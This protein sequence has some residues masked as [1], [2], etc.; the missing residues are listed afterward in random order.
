MQ[1]RVSSS[2][3]LQSAAVCFFSLL[4]V[5]RCNRT[6]V[7]CTAAAEHENHHIL[8]PSASVRVASVAPT[9]I[10]ESYHSKHSDVDT[11]K[12]ADT[13]KYADT[14][15][16]GQSK[17]TMFREPLALIDDSSSA[18]DGSK[19]CVGYQRLSRAYSEDATLKAYPKCE[20][21]PCDDYEAAFKVFELWLVD[22]VV[23]PIENYMDGRIHC[24][25]DLLLRHRLHI[26]GEFLN[27]IVDFM[28]V[29][30]LLFF[31]LAFVWQAALRV[32][33]CLL[34]LPCVTKEEL[35]GV[36]GHPQFSGVN[37]IY[38]LHRLVRLQTL[39]LEYAYMFST[40]NQSFH[41]QALSHYR[42]MLNDLGLDKF[43][44]QDIVVDAKDD[45]ENVTRFLVLAREPRI[46]GP[47]RPRK[48][49]IVF[50]L[51]E[52]PGALFKALSMFFMRG[53]NLS[54]AS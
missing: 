35:N 23:L 34:G 3:S 2:P 28:P 52:G 27:P 51:E 24:N 39:S 22:K 48:T 13:H 46:P 43:S 53:I 9:T 11:H 10:Y 30:P 31:L 45:D 32:N 38:D 14:G 17:N 40:N 33:H 6:T 18:S 7:L 54:R 5:Y 21:V 41:M 1:K 29:I 49:S 25:Y 44:D 47:G 42:T 36:M 20:T 4:D 19:L 12:S 50:S 8:S 16:S 26:V 37:L 15:D